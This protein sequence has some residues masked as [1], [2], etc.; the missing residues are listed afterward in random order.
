LQDLDN[1][2][3]FEV[4]EK[5][6]E[7][8][9]FKEQAYMFI[10]IGKIREATQILIQ[11]SGDDINS[12]VDMALKFGVDDAILWQN[13]LEKVKGNAKQV[14]KL[15]L[16]SDVYAEPEKFI[17]AYPENITLGEI[18]QDLDEM[19]KKIQVFRGLLSSAVTSGERAKW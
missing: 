3:T 4:A 6:K 1:Y 9:L 15:L 5:C 2:K 16:Y 13:L 18:T 11:E 12:A 7:K 8:G 14:G 17:E 10:K 19:F